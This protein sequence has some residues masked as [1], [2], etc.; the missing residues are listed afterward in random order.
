MSDPGNILSSE[1]E[2]WRRL[3]QQF[4]EDKDDR[5]TAEDVEDEE[6]YW[7]A[8]MERREL[9]KEPWYPEPPED[10]GADEPETEVEE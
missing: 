4:R 1:V 3:A 8:E 9:R 6:R 5:M 2:R 10:I 7:E